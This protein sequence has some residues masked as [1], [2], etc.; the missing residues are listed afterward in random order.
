MVKEVPLCVC[1]CWGVVALSASAFFACLS[2]LWIPASC[3][4]ATVRA[5]VFVLAC[6]LPSEDFV[7]S[8]VQCQ[9]HI[10]R[11]WWE[12]P[13]YVALCLLHLF[14]PQNTLEFITPLTLSLLFPSICFFFLCSIYLPDFLLTSFDLSFQISCCLQVACLSTARDHFLSAGGRIEFYITAIE[15]EASYIFTSMF[16]S[17]INCEWND[18]RKWRRSKL[19][20]KHQM[21]LLIWRPAFL[22][23]LEWDACK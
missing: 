23:K 6:M 10:E 19:W 5:R 13:G 17:N 8:A 4:S 20:E 1:V 7:E 18:L 22:V 3:Q 2:L 16:L 21:C 15:P 14:T 9:W 12:S 11:A